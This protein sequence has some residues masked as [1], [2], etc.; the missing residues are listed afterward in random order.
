METPWPIL[1]GLLALALLLAGILWFAGI[2]PWWGALI[3]VIALPV[4]GFLALIFLFY[5]LWIASGSH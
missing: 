3:L 4:G 1:I 5:A 2:V